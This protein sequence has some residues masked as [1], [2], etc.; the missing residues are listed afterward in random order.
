MAA[1]LEV[2][3]EYAEN[4]DEM[5]KRAISFADMVEAT[6]A[7]SR[8]DG[9]PLVEMEAGK[10][11]RTDITVFGLFRTPDYRIHINRICPATR[12]MESGESNDRI[13]SWRHRVQIRPHGT[14][15]IWTD[16]IIID[17]GLLTPV[18]ARYARFMYRHRHTHRRALSIQSSLGR[19]GR[20]VSPDLPMFRPSE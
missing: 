1:D 10:V 2:T 19:T 12:C 7:I 14:G 11:Y 8:Y 5:F 4:A 18:V 6:Q 20:N 13:R 17:A 9:L 3:A 16:H 15:S